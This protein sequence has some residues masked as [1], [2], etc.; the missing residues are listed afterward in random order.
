MTASTSAGQG[1]ESETV[2]EAPQSS[3]PAAVASFTQ[4]VTRAVK[5]DI[6]MECRTAGR[7]K[8]VVTWMYQ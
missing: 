5:E 2:A 3:G 6:T 4:T 8:P 1:P 7:P